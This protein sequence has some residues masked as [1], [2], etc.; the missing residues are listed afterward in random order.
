MTRRLALSL[1]SL[2]LVASVAASMAMP[3]L[4]GAAPINPQATIDARH[5]GFKKIGGAMKT[6]FEQ[7]KSDTPS[8]PAMAAAA[9]AI[10][11]TGKGQG[12]L[13]PAGT[14]PAPGLKTDALPAIWTDKARF[15]AQMAAF[16]TEAGKLVTTVNAGNVE[17]IR[18]Q[19]KALG[20]TCGSCHR[21]FRHD[22]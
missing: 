21:Q 1:A 18:A 22:D 13:F 10:L 8:K 5:A 17:A 2:A 14:A 16:V 6:L 19:T 9:A 4:A 20:G 11:D 15:D 7:L 3:G 12:A